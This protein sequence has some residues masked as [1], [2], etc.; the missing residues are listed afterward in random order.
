MEPMDGIETTSR[1]R[2]KEA[3]FS[4]HQR[5]PIVALTANAAPGDNEQYMRQGMDFFLTKRTFNIC[6]LTF[7]MPF[8]LAIRIPELVRCLDNI[9]TAVNSRYKISLWTNTVEFRCKWQITYSCHD[10]QDDANGNC[11]AKISRFRWWI[12]SLR[13]FAMCTWLRKGQNKFCIDQ[14]WWTPNLFIQIVN[15]AEMNKSYW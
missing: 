6:P 7:L 11:S 4:N 9:T 8:L 15:E 13:T 5:I 2:A 12:T 14:K 10:N 3:Q 1:I